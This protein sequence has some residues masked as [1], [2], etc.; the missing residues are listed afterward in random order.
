M[1]LEQ[2][3]VMYYQPILVL[4]VKML[5]KEQMPPLENQKSVLT[6]TFSCVAKVDMFWLAFK[7]IVWNYDGHNIEFPLFYCFSAAPENGTAHEF[8]CRDDDPLTDFF[9]DFDD[10]P[11][12]SSYNITCT[13]NG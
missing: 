5:T 11:R 10:I 9:F 12:L 3:N 6:T 8:A 13:N 1:E 2:F 4:L 7:I